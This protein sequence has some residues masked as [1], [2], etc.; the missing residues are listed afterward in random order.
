MTAYTD[1][2]LRGV[3]FRTPTERGFADALE[4][5]VLLSLE[6]E[7]DNEHDPNAIKVC[8]KADG[9]DLHLGYVA[10]EAATW[11]APDLDDGHSYRCLVSSITEERGRRQIL[12]D[13]H[14][15]V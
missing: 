2:P 10:R 9:L 14:E 13:L 6:R 8:Y 4:E 5:G 15:D 3:Y 11:I 12:L 7:P 1:I